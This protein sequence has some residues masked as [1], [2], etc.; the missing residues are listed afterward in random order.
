VPSS[1]WSTR[2]MPASTLTSSSI[3][4]APAAC[5]AWTLASVAARLA[6]S[7][8]YVCPVAGAREAMERIAPKLVDNPLIFPT[9]EFLAN[10]FQFMPLGETLN[11]RYRRD[12]AEAI[13][14]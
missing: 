10:S 14:G 11:K 4:S 6:A 3:A 13:G 12:F 5:A 7:V 9:R 8:N 1:L 2:Q